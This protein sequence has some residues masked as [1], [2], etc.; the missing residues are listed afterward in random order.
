KNAAIAITTLLG[1]N[2]IFSLFRQNKRRLGGSKSPQS[3]ASQTAQSTSANGPIGR[4]GPVATIDDATIGPIRTVGSIGS[5][6]NQAVSRAAFATST[7]SAT[8]SRGRCSAHAT[9]S[10][11]SGRSSVSA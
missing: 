1:R 9:G 2:T 7:P 8:R 11:S 10:T 3:R 4:I 5:W 6:P